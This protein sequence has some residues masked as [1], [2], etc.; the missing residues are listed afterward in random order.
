MYHVS[1]YL[2]SKDPSHII[3]KE[4]DKKLEHEIDRMTDKLPPLR[5][6]IQPGGSIEASHLHYARTLTRRVERRYV[7]YSKY[8]TPNKDLLIFFNR[9]SD[10]LFVSARYSNHLKG[11]N[12]VINV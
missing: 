1:A 12:D 9:L 11:V 10:Y 6:L 4:I 5:N 7:K 8:T 3:E 2:A